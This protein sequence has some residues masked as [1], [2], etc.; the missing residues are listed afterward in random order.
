M[1]QGPGMLPPDWESVVVQ[2]NAGTRFKIDQGQGLVDEL[3][4]NLHPSLNQRQTGAHG[5][6]T[7]GGDPAGHDLV[8]WYISGRCTCRS[9]WVD[10][11][12]CGVEAKLDMSLARASSCRCQ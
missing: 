8:A 12:V 9:S 3:K 10:S 5:G 1:D 4:N 11:K 6:Q 7:H 2:I